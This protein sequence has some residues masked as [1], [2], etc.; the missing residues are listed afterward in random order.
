[1]KK[2]YKRLMAFLIGH[3][4]AY[5]RHFPGGSKYPPGLPSHSL[6][7][8]AIRNLNPISSRIHSASQFDRFIRPTPLQ[9]PPPF[10]RDTVLLVIASVWYSDHGESQA[11][12]K[13][14]TK[15][16][17]AYGACDQARRRTG[18]SRKPDERKSDGIKEQNYC[19]KSNRCKYPLHSHYW[20]NLAP[21]LSRIAKMNAPKGESVYGTHK[22]VG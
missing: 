14:S 12:F 13:A 21:L 9:A 10:P 3:L 8:I 4:M 15:L 17:R 18:T 22:R 19:R 7:R 16:L 20:E 5:K 11:F 6:P 2:S 1:M